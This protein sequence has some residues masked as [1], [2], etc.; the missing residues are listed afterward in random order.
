MKKGFKEVPARFDFGKNERRLL[1]WWYRSG[2]VERYLKRNQNSKKRFSF[3]DGPITANNPMGVHHAWGRTLKDLYQRYKNMQGFKQRFQNGFDCQGLWVEVEVEKEKGFASKKDIQKYGIAKFVEDCKARV[4]K[5]SKI[6]TKQSI[7]LGYFMD[8][9]NSYYTMSEENNYM[10]WH[11]LKRCWQEGNIYK[12]TDSVPWCP[13]CGTAI[14]Q[15]EMSE[16]GYQK[17]THKA[18]YLRFP[19][20]R[21]G[22][23]S[24]DEFLL[25]WTTTPWTIPADTLVAVHPKIKYAQVEFEG[26]RYWLAKKLLRRVFDKRPAIHKVLSGEELVEKEGIDRYLAPFDD[27]PII[28]RVSKSPHFHRLILAEELVNEEEGTGLVHIVPGAGTE[29][30]RLTKQLGWLDVIFPVV[31]E[32]GSYIKGYG[33]LSGKNAKKHPEIVIEH[34]KKKEGGAYLFK[35][36]DYTHSYP[37]CWRCKTELIWRLVDEWYIA[38]DKKDKGDGKTLRERMIEVAK[39]IRWLP[40]FGLKRELDW[41]K[42]MGDWMISKK[43]FWGLALPIWECECGH[44]EVIGSKEELKKRAVEGWEEFEGH[45]PHRPWIDKVKIACSL[46]GQKMSRVADVGNPWLDAGIVPFS[47]LIDPKSG[48]VSYLDDKKYWRRWYPADFITECFPGQFRNWFYSLIA[49]ATVLEDSR[50]FKT[51]LG[52][53]LVRDEKGEEMHKSKG[54]AIWFDEAAEKMGVDTMRWLYARQN[55]EFNLNFGYQVADEV[56]RQFIL[57]YWNTYRFF[58]TYSNLNGWRPKGGFSLLGTSLGVLDRWILSK[59]EA[60]KKKVGERLD[61]YHHHEALAAIEEFLEDLSLWYVRRSR[62][63]VNPNNPDKKDRQACLSTLF[64]VLKQLSLVLAPFIPFLTETVWQNLHGFGGNWSAE[65]SVHLQDWPKVEEKL[66]D[67]RLEERMAFV[68]EVVSLGHAIR[69]EKQIKVRQPLRKFEI[70]NLK[71]EIDEELV[72]LIKDELNVKEVGFEVGRGR[73]KVKLDTKITPEL[74]A[75]GE[76]RELIRQIQVLRRQKGLKV[77]DKITI[78]APSWPKKWEREILVRTNAVRIQK[79]ARLEIKTSGL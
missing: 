38:M 19:V 50:P 17:R 68:R 13:R 2:V 77:T 4:R 12:G 39:K 67:K 76:A 21:G 14:S 60:T 65:D 46:C 22:K 45:T 53:A 64:Y 43:R 20:V 30:H 59:L 42:N 70:Q 56:R 29:D 24:R 47:T 69:K 63:R 73:L 3:L 10:I 34:L 44:F 72:Q 28:K 75:E 5:Y 49:M 61:D 66:I 18:V 62:E 9:D 54:N 78:F 58:I 1:D 7:R 23:V 31:D 32:E 25:V 36:K 40:E 51:V 71:F 79:A 48:K 6:Q 16:G 41:L 8:W 27:L 74:A 52:H 57:L 11:F 35:T 33:F 55:P 37:I 15:Q 26:K